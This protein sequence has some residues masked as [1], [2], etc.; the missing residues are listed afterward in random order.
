MADTEGTPSV[1]DLAPK[2]KEKESAGAPAPPA[3]SVASPMLVVFVVFA[4]ATAAGS[5][6]IHDSMIA[7]L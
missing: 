1:P 2:E 6:R 3:W 5:S 7:G 4:A